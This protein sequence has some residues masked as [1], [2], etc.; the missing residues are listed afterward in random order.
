MLASNDSFVVDMWRRRTS[1]HQGVDAVLDSWLGINREIRAAVCASLGAFDRA[2]STGSPGWKA[3]CEGDL[4]GAI[5]HAE[6]LMSKDSTG[7]VLYGEALFAS[8]AIVPALKHLDAFHLAGVPEASL[9]L[10]RKLFEFGDYKGAQ[11]VLS[12]LPMHAQAVQ[13]GARAALSGGNPRAAFDMLFP[14]MNGSVPIPDAYC[15]ASFAV[16]AATSLAAMGE[17][18]N[19]SEFGHALL[20][21]VDADVDVYPLVARVAWLA[22]LGKEAWDRY[23]DEQDDD[24][25]CAVARIELALL[26]GNPQLA[27]IYVRK[28]GA[29][30]MPSINT[31]SLLEGVVP[32]GRQDS[33]KLGKLFRS[34][35]VIHIWRTHAYRWQ[36][37]IN[38]A[39]ATDAQVEVYDLA[40]DILPDANVIPDLAIDDE[41]LWGVL[42]PSPIPVSKPNGHGVWIEGALCSGVG[43]GYDWPA[44]E[45]ETIVQQIEAA[46]NIGTASVTVARDEDAFAVAASGRAA[47]A[48]AKPG[49]P[50]WS[51][52]LPE[53]LWPSLKVVKPDFGKK[54]IWEGAGHRVVEAVRALEGSVR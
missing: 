12:T 3:L 31:L 22:G 26:A 10:G 50:F 52:P 25:W 8:G 42:P 7:V 6:T 23:G 33:E 16:V 29:Y 45:T 20:Q 47:V 9:S 28:A 34:G 32:P 5:K 21:S 54:D 11:N 39:L 46:G 53:K 48:I 4:K 43:V 41:R 15:A 24:P 13:I 27:R 30:A 35:I 17:Y 40:N 1:R 38:A 44:S 14:F 2:A 49:E 36:P 18:R 19:L 37:W 51:G